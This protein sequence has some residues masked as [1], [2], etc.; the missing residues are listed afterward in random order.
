MT[1]KA[2]QAAFLLGHSHM[3]MASL[4]KRFLGHT[5]MLLWGRKG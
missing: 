2:A 4:L 1:K 3:S 5:P